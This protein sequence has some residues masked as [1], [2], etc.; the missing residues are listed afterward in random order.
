M[1]LNN[2]FGNTDDTQV[3]SYS[4]ENFLNHPGFLGGTWWKAFCSPKKAEAER[5]ESNLTDIKN[6]CG[7]N[8]AD[9]NCSELED[10]YWCLDDEKQEAL[11]GGTGSRGQRRV[12]DRALGN[13]GPLIGD[14]EKF[15]NS[16]DCEGG[17]SGLDN[18]YDDIDL[19]QK[20]IADTNLANEQAMMKM[21]GQTQMM[22]MQQ[23]MSAD[24]EKK[25]LMY[26]GAGII[27]VMLIV[28]MVKSK[29]NTQTIQTT[30]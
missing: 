3:E 2:D 21:Q 5:A 15:Q 23:K 16:R 18:A 30:K 20:E 28:M 4:D 12:R 13:V 6:S 7:S 25:T 8:F 11:A 22:M 14:V 10:S 29:N 27:G 24:K 19:Y 1:W 26:L 17:T 9:M